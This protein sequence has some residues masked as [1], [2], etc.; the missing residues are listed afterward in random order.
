MII[1]LVKEADYEKLVHLFRSFFK[2]H[3]IFQQPAAKILQYLR[4]QAVENPLLV[5]EDKGAL[6]GALF[7]VKI[8]ENKE[9]THKIWKFRHFAFLTETIAAQ[10]LDDAEKHV[11][12]SSRTGKIELTIAE[13][14]PGKAFYLKHGYVQE[15]A[16][17]DHYRPGETCYVLG[18]SFA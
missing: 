7:L 15:G 5:Y 13:T 12:K 14:E 16:L 3:N 17:K 1:R 8:G 9:G 2:T 6:Q 4:E 11:Q 18:K 10:L